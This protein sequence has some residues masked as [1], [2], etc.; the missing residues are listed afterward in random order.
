[1][2]LASV[3]VRHDE[4]ITEAL[5]GT[6]VLPST[7]SDLK[8]DLRDDRSMAEPAD[9]GRASV[10][11]SRRHRDE[12]DMGRLGQKPVTACRDSRQGRWAIAR[13]SGSRRRGEGGQARLVGV[14]EAHEGARAQRRPFDH[15]GCLHWARRERSGF[16]SRMPSLILVGDSILSRITMPDP[17]AETKRIQVDG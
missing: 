2:Y 17:G 12:A 10:C 14:P 13:S 3:S 9:R 11:L 16:L 6:R 5:C 8:E 7:V 1:M 15:L 4:D